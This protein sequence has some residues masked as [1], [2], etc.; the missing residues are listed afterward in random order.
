MMSDANDTN[1]VKV[2]YILYLVGILIPVMSIIGVVVAYVF[3][4][5][6]NNT[7]QSHYTFQIRTFWISLL[8][9]LIGWLTIFIGI[10]WL[11]LALWVIWLIVRCVKGLRVVSKNLPYPNPQTWLID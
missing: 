10:G 5:D 7:V 4:G 9:Q 6:A 11:V 2:I 1:T 3:R 8:F